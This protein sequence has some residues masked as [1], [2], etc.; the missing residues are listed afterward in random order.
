MGCGGS[1]T[2]ALCDT[3][4]IY[5]WGWGEQG[6]L[7]LGS[8]TMT[9]YPTLL[10]DLLDKGSTPYLLELVGWLTGRP[11]VTDLLIC[12]SHSAALTRTGELYC[13]GSSTA[14]QVGH[15]T[16]TAIYDTPKLVEH[17]RTDTVEDI[18]VSGGIRAGDRS[19]TLRRL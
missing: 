17:F 5:V 15:D 2:V 16:S 1:N 19:A 4:E 9:R 12:G 7:G 3:G 11:G 10:E 6:Q 13:W 8:T 14:G 18:A